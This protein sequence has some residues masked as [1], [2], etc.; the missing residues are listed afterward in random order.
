M[1]MHSSNHTHLTRFKSKFVKTLSN[2]LLF[3]FIGCF[4]Y[5]KSNLKTILSPYRLMY[6]CTGIFFQAVHFT[7]PKCLQNIHILDKIFTFLRGPLLWFS[8]L[9]FVLGQH[10]PWWQTQ[11]FPRVGSSLGVS[12]RVW[13]R[14]RIS[15]E[16]SGRGKILVQALYIPPS[17]QLVLLCFFSDSNRK[18]V[19][20]N[21]LWYKTNF[22]FE[23]A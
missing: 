22:S 7:V 18:S 1:Y 8:W 3:A 23:S 16:V 17:L 10:S 6:T 11:G 9:V 12:H 15:A 2:N 4:N 20:Q 21:V 19:I 13:W 5:R 14:G